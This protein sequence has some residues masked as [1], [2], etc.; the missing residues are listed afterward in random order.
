M[1]LDE[2][3]DKD[4]PWGQPTQNYSKL[5]HK[6]IDMLPSIKSMSELKILIYT[7]RHTWGYQDSFKGMTLDE[8]MNGRKRK[9]G[10]RIDSG[11]GLSRPSVKDGINKAV[12]HGYLF[13]AENNGD[14]ARIKRYYSLEKSGI[15]EAVSK[16]RGARFLPPDVKILTPRCKDSYPRTE[17]E[18][19]VERNPRK[20]PDSKAKKPALRDGLLINI[21]EEMVNG[22]TKTRGNHTWVQSAFNA[23]ALRC[24]NCELEKDIDKAIYYFEG[25]FGRVSVNYAGKV[26]PCPLYPYVVFLNRFYLPSEA[27]GKGERSTRLLD[28]P[29]TGVNL[30]IPDVEGGIIRFT[31]DIEKALPYQISNHKWVAIH[32]GKK[33]KVCG[34]VKLKDNTFLFVDDVLND[35]IVHNNGKTPPCPHQPY[36]DFVNRVQSES[37]PISPIN[38]VDTKENCTTSKSGPVFDDGFNFKGGGGAGIKESPKE[39]PLTKDKVEAM[40]CGVAPNGLAEEYPSEVTKVYRE[41]ESGANCKKSKSLFMGSEAQMRLG[42]AI[43]AFCYVFKKYYPPPCTGGEWG[44][45]MAGC[46]EHLDTLRAVDGFKDG[47]LLDF[48]KKAY[49]KW[50]KLK[51]KT[52]I[53]RPQGIDY[54][55]GEV[56]AEII[57]NIKGDNNASSSASNTKSFNPFDN[58]GDEYSNKTWEEIYSD[59]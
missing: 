1:K 24:A 8:Y 54:L 38:R 40:F 9:D 51:K 29:F 43:A 15:N 42:Y 55:L 25:D 45:A 28:S 20:K 22:I 32:R 39:L 33:C 2:Y 36:E 23:G 14:K 6:F 30:G 31:P 16:N 11:T 41:I 19:L 58:K 44:Q 35:I 52:T 12:S 13:V 18:T 10:S 49:S 3:M 59:A 7:L 47:D 37:R 4:T 48:Y 21:T 5:P 46:K 27:K 56:K 53:S 50:T 34:L 26:P 17:K 57:L